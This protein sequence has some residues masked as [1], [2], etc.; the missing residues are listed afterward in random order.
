MQPAVTDNE[1]KEIRICK[2]YAQKIYGNED[3][4]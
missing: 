3:L 4:E 1:N 2:S